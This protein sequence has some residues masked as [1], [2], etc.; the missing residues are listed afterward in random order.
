MKILLLHNYYQYRG[1]EDVYFD[2]L[3]KLLQER[4]HNVFTYTKNSNNIQ[5]LKDK[6]KV[7][8]GLFWS[9]KI[10]KELTKLIKRCKPD[11]AQ[12][13]NIFPLITPT[14]YF[15]CKKY[16]I[17]IVQRVSNYR[18]ACPKGILFRNS[19]ICEL[20][21]NK[22]FAYPSILYGCYHNSRISSLLLSSSLYL[23]KQSMIF[24]LIDKFIFPTKFIRD[25]YVKN[26]KIPILET[27]IIPTF[28]IFENKQKNK[29]SFFKSIKEKGYFLFVGRLS[30]EK[31]LFQ[32]LEI[33]KNLPNI[34][35]IIIGD[36]P[37]KE[38]VK[39]Y[40][41]Y[42]NIKIIDHLPHSLIENYIS[43]ALCVI[44]PSIWYEV[45]P[46]VLI[47]SFVK[48]IPVLVPRFGSFKE[49]INNY[50]NGVFYK[51]NH[52]SDLKAK[53]IEIENNKN[54]ISKM[55]KLMQKDYHNIYSKNSHYQILTNL[56][57]ELI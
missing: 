14:A 26:V 28:S 30:E 17:P 7:T 8:F 50:K 49:I 42:T 55:K 19:K 23:H 43:H 25:Y 16:N 37:E 4:G 51:P 10:E 40:A 21:I 2:S 29:D 34:K 33:F 35:L 56:Y 15:V 3:T 1:G 9:R 41:I 6:V 38:E 54:L 45:L 44:I 18:F 13:Q 53:I 5:S 39:K 24:K 11:I 52:P 27:K 31:G 22:Q 57:R 20:C 47:E 12:F 46:N 48:H 32:I 36:G